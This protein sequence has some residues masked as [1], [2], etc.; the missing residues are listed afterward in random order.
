MEVA[1]W[2]E[3]QDMDGFLSAFS[4]VAKVRPWSTVSPVQGIC[5]SRAFRTPRHV[6]INPRWLLRNRRCTVQ[7]PK[8]VQRVLMFAQ[9]ATVACTVTPLKQFSY[10]FPLGLSK[11][12]NILE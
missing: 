6:T 4:A 3:K 12:G 5:C 7:Q 2:A 1:T 11:S 8:A 9:F 10:V